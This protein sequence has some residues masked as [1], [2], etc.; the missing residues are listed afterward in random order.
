M[1]TP[2]DDE[3]SFFDMS[4]DMLCCLGFDGHFMRLNKA[5][6]R[7]L[8][9]TIEELKARPFIEFV[10]P[11]DR[12]R[13]L[14]QNA[15]VR[16]GGQALAFENRITPINQYLYDTLHFIHIFVGFQ[17]LKQDLPQELI[18]GDEVVERVAGERGPLLS[19]FDREQSLL[20][21]QRLSG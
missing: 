16:A 7:T 17:D 2:P 5:W 4:I 14:A 15:A 9:F 10:H 12:L 18:V 19:V 13:T 6:E 8:G 3:S 21:L 1:M 20:A 11:D